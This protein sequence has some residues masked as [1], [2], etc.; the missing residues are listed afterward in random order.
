MMIDDKLNYKQNYLRVHNPFSV[1]PI[2]KKYKLI[3]VV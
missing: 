2:K 1:L 3:I